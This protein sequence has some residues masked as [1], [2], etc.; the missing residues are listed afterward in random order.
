M[1]RKNKRVLDY[2]DQ[3]KLDFMDGNRVGKI[4]TVRQVLTN[5]LVYKGEENGKNYKP[6]KKLLKKINCDV[7]YD[8]MYE[9]MF[10]LMKDKMPVDFLEENYDRLFL[11]PDYLGDKSARRKFDPLPLKGSEIFVD[12]GC[13]PN[14]Q[15]KQA[16][17]EL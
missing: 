15:E 2:A 17:V 9:L 14:E 5:V 11:L 10:A 8:F 13:F 12:E 7:D 4:I 16:R 1:G 6:S 3:H